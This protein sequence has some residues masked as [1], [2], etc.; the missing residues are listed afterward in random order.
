MSADPWFSRCAIKT[1]LDDVL[2]KQTAIVA[3][4]VQYTKRTT[5]IP[6]TL[7]DSESLY[8]GVVLYSVAILGYIT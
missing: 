6:V 2:F 7:F 4:G 3:V 5:T 8:T 1:P